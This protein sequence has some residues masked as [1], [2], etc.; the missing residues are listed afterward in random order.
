MTEAQAEHLLSILSRIA[1]ALEGKK[2][3]P[4]NGTAKEFDIR[5]LPLSVRARKTLAHAG[6]ESWEQLRATG[7]HVLSEY[8]GCGKTTLREIRE[9][10]RE[11]NAPRAGVMLKGV[12]TEDLRNVSDAMNEASGRPY[13]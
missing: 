11:F 9:V 5:K 2:P 12:T 7:D 8:K 6:I 1:D 10:E 13:E 3:A 4:S